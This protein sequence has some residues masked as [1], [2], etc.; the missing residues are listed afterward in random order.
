MI[1]NGKH[2]VDLIEGNAA[3][4]ASVNE[5][6]DWGHSPIGGSWHDGTDGPLW[7]RVLGLATCLVLAIGFV[8]FCF[9]LG[10]R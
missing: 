6:E 4:R 5:Y 2:Y 1:V 8:A 10:L 3:H 9:Y 7:W